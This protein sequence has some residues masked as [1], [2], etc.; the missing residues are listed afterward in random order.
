VVCLALAGSLDRDGA[1]RLFE[2]LGPLLSRRTTR[3]VVDLEQLEYINSIGYGMII[4]LLKRASDN[5]SQLVLSGLRGFVR[6]NFEQMNYTRLYP[7][8]ETSA[9]AIAALGREEHP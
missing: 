4:R 2:E 6:E 9:E 3:V 7:V 5:R 1:L 8:Y